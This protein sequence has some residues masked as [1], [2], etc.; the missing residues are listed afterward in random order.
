[1]FVLLGAKGFGPSLFI[2]LVIYKHT[3]SSIYF[4]NLNLARIEMEQEL[5]D[6]WVPTLKDQI[7]PWVERW[8]IKKIWDVAHDQQ[9]TS[10]LLPSG[11]RGGLQTKPFFLGFFFFG[12]SVRGRR[13]II[14][15][16]AQ[17]LAVTDR[18][19]CYQWEIK[20][21]MP[22]LIL[23]WNFLHSINQYLSTCQIL[24]REGTHFIVG[25]K[26]RGA[27]GT[28]CKIGWGHPTTHDT[29]HI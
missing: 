23:H 28:L 29:Y 2:W 11:H 24:E 19:F 8:R 18:Y 25:I 27:S 1:M 12:L 20:Q 9:A 7:N 10:S 26:E 15:G 14:V 16:L 17:G 6:F 4:F 5:E 3:C 21:S 13:K 22:N